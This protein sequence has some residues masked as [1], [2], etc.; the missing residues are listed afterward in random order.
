MQTDNWDGMVR[1]EKG[2]KK[3]TSRPE[4]ECVNCQHRALSCDSQHIFGVS[5]FAPS[6][7]ERIQSSRGNR[8]G[9]GGGREGVVS[10]LF[11]HQKF[12][13]HGISCFEGVSTMTKVSSKLQA[14]RKLQGVL[15]YEKL[16]SKNAG[17]VNF[18]LNLCGLFLMFLSD[19]QG[20]TEG[21]FLP[22]RCNALPACER[23][24]IPC[25]KN[26]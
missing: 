10:H 25:A 2:T 21:L 16:V 11:P 15:R 17:M 20:G 26:F 6:A 12:S 4:K 1:N 5:R 24:G 13:L 3:C 18:V 19:A 7:C 22:A 9:G 8:E 14:L 23:P